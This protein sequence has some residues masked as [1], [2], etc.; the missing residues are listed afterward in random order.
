MYKAM[1]KRDKRNRKRFTI[2]IVIKS[3]HFFI[4]NLYMNHPNLFIDK[5]EK[6]S[7]CNKQK[8]HK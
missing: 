1:A 7:D 8:S 5:N 3:K 2:D 6:K 4:K